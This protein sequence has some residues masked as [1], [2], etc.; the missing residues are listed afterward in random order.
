MITLVRGR[1]VANSLAAGPA[2]AD[3]VYYADEQVTEIQHRIQHRL[4]LRYTLG[5]WTVERTNCAGE[6]RIQSEAFAAV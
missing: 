3:K 5:Y 1:K 4:Q 6:R 2:N